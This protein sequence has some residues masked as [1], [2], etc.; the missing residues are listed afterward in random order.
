MTLKK[1]VVLAWLCLGVLVSMESAWSLERVLGGAGL[2]GIHGLVVAG[3][4]EIIVG[5]LF[6][7]SIYGIDPVTGNRR[8]VVPPPYGAADDLVLD[9]QSR[10]VWTSLYAGAVYRQEADGRIKTLAEGLPGV[11]GLAFD[12]KG[13]LFVSQVFLGDALYEIDVNGASPPRKI[14]ENIGGLNGFDFDGKGNLYGPLWFKGQ[15]VRVDVDSA[16]VTVL[17]DM[18]TVPSSVK[19]D[20]QGS[21]WVVD[22]GAGKL[23]RINTQTGMVEASIS[24][25]TGMD[26]LAFDHANT[27]YVSVFADSALYKVDI[28]SERA[29]PLMTYPLGFPS[30]IALLESK[31]RSLIYVADTFSVKEFDLAGDS[32]RS[33]ARGGEQPLYSAGSG[34][35]VDEDH[36]Y[37][38]GGNV[39]DVL[40]RQTGS[41]V[42]SYQNIPGATDV[43]GLSEDNLIVSL[44]GKGEVWRIAGDD[45]WPIA[46]D[47]AGPGAMIRDGV[48]RILV[49]LKHSGEVVSIVV[50]TGDIEIVASNLLAPEGMVKVSACELLVAETGRKQLS[51]IN[52]D[53]GKLVRSFEKLPIGLLPIFSTNVPSTKVPGPLTGLVVLSS[54]DVLMSSDVE[55]AL[56]RIHIQGESMPGVGRSCANKT[57]ESPR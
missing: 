54:G 37:L 49:S 29:E 5:S 12:M 45:R 3:N 11:N 27:G 9:Q 10:L 52:T 56:Y 1:R 17:S 47:L 18:L 40:D 13:R 6:G 14:L 35:D 44:A 42:R 43:I 32:V 53:S 2:H 28:G 48:G 38:A 20:Q 19:F 24:L 50:E 21:L 41:V 33:V 7:Q 39:V 16:E 57:V 46:S 36:I 55:D 8:V 25:P 51:M 4:G 34:I 30:D 15:V 22:T 23:L 31:T 26:N